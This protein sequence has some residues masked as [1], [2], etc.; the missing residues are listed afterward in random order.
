MLYHSY[1]CTKLVK[2]GEKNV[3][4]IYVGLGWWGHPAVPPQAQRFP[5]G[6]PTVRALLRVQQQQQQGVEVGGGFE[7]GTDAT[8]QQTQGPVIYDDEYN[9]QTYDARLETPGWTSAT[10]IYPSS[11]SPPVTT[12][13][14][15]AAEATGGATLWTPVV[16]SASQPKFT[17][18]HT[19]LSSAAFQPIKVLTRRRPEWMRS[20]A[21]GVFVFDFTQNEPGWC[22]LD[23]TCTR[24]LVVQ[25]RHAEVLQHPPY[26]P[27]DGNV[28]VGNLRSAKATDV[29]VCKGD[30]AGE[31][32][33][34][35]FTQHGFRY[36]ELTFPGANGAPPAPSLE[37]LTA[38]NTRS[39][40]D[41]AGDLTFSDEVLQKVHH[42]YLW[43][44]ASNLMMIPSD[45]DNRDER[46]GWTGD[47]ALT[48]DEASVNFDLSAFYDSWARMLDDGSQDGQV[49]CWIPGGP[50]HAGGCDASWGSAFPSVVYAQF[51]WQGA[52]LRIGLA[53]TLWLWPV[54]G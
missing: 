31:S 15:A 18:S 10:E 38:I 13:P 21:P 45:C 17:L 35:S 29:Y 4:A 49:P 26:G 46:F 27:E 36:V 3:L 54:S 50:G 2:P 42:N 1:D 14:A 23:I 47:S 28:Y 48:A 20:P 19:I 37:T 7:L 11:P 52:G 5:F 16:L 24:G 34:F 40:V 6:P 43:G 25:L 51:K 41:I 33:E 22:K 44:Q 39:A 32:L 8:W 12:T 9:G 30:P 53:P